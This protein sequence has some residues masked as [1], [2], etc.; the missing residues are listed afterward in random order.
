MN[1]TIEQTTEQKKLAERFL[2]TKIIE[3]SGGDFNSFEDEI[4]QIANDPAH[5]IV[6]E[7]IVEYSD[8]QLRKYREHLAKCLEDHLKLNSSQ[9]FGRSQDMAEGYNDAVE[10]IIKTLRKD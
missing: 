10:F 1:K 6:V 7:A 2:L 9:M 3:A 5:M 8:Q 4:N